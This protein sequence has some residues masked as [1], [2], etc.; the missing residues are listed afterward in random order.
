MPEGITEKDLSEKRLTVVELCKE[1]KYNYTD[2]LH[3]TLWGN[4]RGV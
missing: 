2:R 4:K 1:H 3:I